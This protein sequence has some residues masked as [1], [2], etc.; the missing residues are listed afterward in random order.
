MDDLEVARDKVEREQE[1]LL[2]VVKTMS[3]TLNQRINAERMVL[4]S[5][6]LVSCNPFGASLKRQIIKLPAFPIR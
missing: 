3:N 2:E 5:V 4:R 1:C 6:T